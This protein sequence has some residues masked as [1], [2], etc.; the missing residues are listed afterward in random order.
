MLSRFISALL[1]TVFAQAALAA[2]IPALTDKVQK[3]Y[4]TL[5]AFS[6][7][8]TQV[9]V[10]AASK[11]KETRTGRLVF[12]QPALIRWDTEKPEKEL[13]VVGKDVV[14]NAF[15]E[16]KAAYRYAVEDVL[17]SKTM[18]RF[19]SGKGNLRED[20][21]IQEEQGAPEGQ[22]KLKLVPRE[23]EPSMVLAY[24][25]VDS[26]SNMLARISIEDF[27]GNINDVT[28]ANV[29]LNPSVPKDLFQY[30]PPKEYSIFDNTGLQGKPKQ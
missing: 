5:S 22:V 24:A 11:E 12:A 4:Q 3:N 15:P 2:D 23:A 10:N 27:Y 21:H 17:G 30:T 16:E 20:F 28:L 26:K 1:F 9:L 13:L 29:K 8:F 25:W 18:L 19:L 14:W 6:A 7:D